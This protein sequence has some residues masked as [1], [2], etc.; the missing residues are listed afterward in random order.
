MSRAQAKRRMAGGRLI[1]DMAARGIVVRAASRSGVADETGFAY[2][3]L[4]TVVAV[5]HRFH[6][7]R[8]GNLKGRARRGATAP[9]GGPR[10]HWGA[11]SRR[12]T[13]RFS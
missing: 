8:I 1:R 2:K 9:A 11:L 10:P 5:F 12:A 6:L 7:S 13:P 4:S 3:D